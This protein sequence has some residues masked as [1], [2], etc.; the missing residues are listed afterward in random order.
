MKKKLTVFVAF[1]S[2]GDVSPLLAVAGH[3]QSRQRVVF[4]SNEYFRSYIEQQGVNFHPIGTIE[5]QLAAKESAQSTGETKVGRMHRFE[6]IIGKSFSP[7]FQYL[8]GL[9]EDGNDL[10]VVSHGN[11]SPAVLACEAFN[12]PLIITHYAPSQIPNNIEDVIMFES[13]YGKNEWIL[14]HLTT[15]VKTFFRKLRFD[16]KE[17]YN[18]YRV[19]HGLQPLPGIAEHLWRKLTFRSSSNKIGAFTPLEIV[20]APKWFCEPADQTFPNLRF[21]G[22][23]FLEEKRNIDEALERFLQSHQKPVVFTPGTAVEDVRDFCEQIVPICRKLG[24]PGIFASKHGKAAFDA[25]E[26]PDDVPLFYLEHADFPSLL[27]RA[28]CL[29]HHGGIGTVA[30]AILAGVPQIIRP[31]MY[32]QSPNAFRVM[33]YGLGG[34]IAPAGY[35]ANMVANILLHIES[36]PR[37]QECLKYYSDLVRKESGVANCCQLIEQYLGEDAYSGESFSEYL[38]VC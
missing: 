1:G 17:S 19:Q 23:P 18:E 36:S 15:P 22:F 24:A 8:K 9:I 35:N 37:H 30:Q 25:L 26:K 3:L 38:E 29:I 34:C 11:L 16:V 2:L 14:R 27:P 12:I 28:R 7:T 5:D 21:A 10:L 31:R 4:L 33:M 32:D 20:L 6:H 13:F